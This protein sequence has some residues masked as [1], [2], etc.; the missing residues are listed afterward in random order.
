[1]DLPQVHH[2]ADVGEKRQAHEHHEGEEENEPS[3]Q[4]ALALFLGS[5]IQAGLEG[6]RHVLILE[7]SSQYLAW[8]TEP[9]LDDIIYR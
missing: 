3:A 8:I 1:M 4:A 2:P 7:P 5:G 6:L 9:L